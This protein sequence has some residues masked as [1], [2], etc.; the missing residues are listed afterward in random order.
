MVRYRAKKAPF[1][2][3]WNGIF[4]RKKARQ[5]LVPGCVVR[6]M[7]YVSEKDGKTEYVLIDKIKDGTCWGRIL[8][9]Y[10]KDPEWDFLPTG[11]RIKFR[12]SAVM[13]IPIS[14][15]PKRLQRKLAPTRHA[16]RLGRPITGAF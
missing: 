9:K 1:V 11:M 2:T 3:D 16:Q 6:V 14:W 8:D 15:Q 7:I 13:E 5:M 4:L 12:L 10:W